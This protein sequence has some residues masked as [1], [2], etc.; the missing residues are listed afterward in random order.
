MMPAGLYTFTSGVGSPTYAAHW[1]ISPVFCD[2]RMV[3]AKAPDGYGV[4]RA[5]ILRPFADPEPA[6]LTQM[7]RQRF[8]GRVRF[9]SLAALAPERFEGGVVARFPKSREGN[10]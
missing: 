4:D 8:E 10:A 2:A 6:L 9:Q 5:I 3:Q 7:L 1:L